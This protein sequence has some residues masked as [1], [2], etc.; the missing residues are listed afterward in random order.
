V[1]VVLQGDGK[2]VS[3]EPA[4]AGDTLVIYCTG[5]GPVTGPMT[6]GVL[7]SLTTL[8]TTTQTPTVSVG[9]VPADVLFSGQ[10]PGTAGVYQINVRL[11]A[12]I[13]SGGTPLV[14]SIGGQTS[15]PFNLP[16]R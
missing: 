16:T 13:P 9:D 11:R 12:G 6:T 2:P 15:A 1:Y 14:V 5:L 4:G 3:A 10:T 8:S 7:A